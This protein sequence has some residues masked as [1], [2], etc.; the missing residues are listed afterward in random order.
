[1]R[2]VLALVVVAALGIGVLAG[3][4]DDT[5]VVTDTLPSGKVTTQTVPDIRFAKTKFLIHTGL[6]FGA[7]YRYIYT[8]FKDGKFRSGA[9]GRRGALVKAGLAGLF[10]Y[11]ELK[12]ARKDALASDTLRRYVVRPMDELLARL[13]P[14]TDALK[15]GSFDPG[16][17]IGAAGAVSALSSAAS[18]AGVD[19]KSRSAPIPGV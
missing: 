19:I 2:R 13:K 11:H 16:S 18:R 9:D 17:I 12:V 8:P 6:A 15:G 10:A 14:L 4:G 3:C 1:V 7:F 5:K